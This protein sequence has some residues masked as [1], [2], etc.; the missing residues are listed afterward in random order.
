MSAMMKL[1]KLYEKESMPETFPSIRG[2]IKNIFL[3]EAIL[4]LIQCSS[5]DS[6][7]GFRLW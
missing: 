1:S 4:E 3:I 2:M 5:C 7:S 6:S